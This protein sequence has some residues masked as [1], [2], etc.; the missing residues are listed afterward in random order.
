LVAVPNVFGIGVPGNF[1]Y[2]YP[3]YQRFMKGSMFL[4]NN[5]IRVDETNAAA[6]VRRDAL[7]TFVSDYNNIST[8]A[9]AFAAH[10]LGS[11]QVSIVN[12]QA[13]SGQDLSSIAQNPFKPTAPGLGNWSLAESGNPGK[14]ELHFT[15]YPGNVYHAPK[16]PG[17]EYDI[18]G[19][20][21]SEALAVMGADEVAPPNANVSG[22]EFY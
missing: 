13:V 8:T 11:P 9:S 12:Y 1:V 17:V 10:W 18:D 3:P 2:S 4:R 15:A 22:W 6:I 20:P 5:I 7:G 14:A 19:E 16:V 21:R